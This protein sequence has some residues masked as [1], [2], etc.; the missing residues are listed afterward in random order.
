LSADAALYATAATAGDPLP[1]SGGLAGVT[2]PG[3]AP[4]INPSTAT[5]TIGPQAMEGNLKLN[6]GTLLQVGFD[7]TMPGSHP[8]TAVSFI[9]P[10]ATFA[11]T[12]VSG[13]GSGSW[14]VPMLNYGYSDPTNS[15]SWYPTGDQDSALAYQVLMPVPNLCSGGP[16][17]FQHGGTFTTGIH[18]TEPGNKVNVRWH[19]S[20]GG[21]VGGWSS[22]SSAVP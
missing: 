18:S 20:G 10:Q 7:F 9:G 16:V 4:Y 21:S 14:V 1:S 12:C 8:S 15:P 19:Y 13:A 5:V 22:T 6:P 3:A 17:R 11:W 2:I